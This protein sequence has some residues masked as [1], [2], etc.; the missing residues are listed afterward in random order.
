MWS[1]YDSHQVN[2]TYLYKNR[3]GLGCNN[4]FGLVELTWLKEISI[5]KPNQKQ[6]QTKKRVQQKVSPRN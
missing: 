6:K 2:I 1:I 4:I 5:C 3:V